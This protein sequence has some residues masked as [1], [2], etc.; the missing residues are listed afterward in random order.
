[1][2]ILET[3][4]QDYARFPAAQ[5]YSIYAPNVHFR[6]PVYDFHGIDRYKDMIK[7]ITT[8]FRNLKL[9]LHSIEQKADT[10]T[11]TWT[12]SWQAPLPWQPVITVSG[13]TE[14]KLDQNQQ[15]CAHYDYWHCTKWDVIKQHFKLA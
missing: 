11:T 12:M 8:W 15:I 13:W 5:T 3:I 1:M 6:D 7:F 10:I 9:E 4:K 14:L 2:D